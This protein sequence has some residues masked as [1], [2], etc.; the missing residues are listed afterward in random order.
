MVINMANKAFLKQSHKDVTA[1]IQLLKNT[2]TAPER[3]MDVLETYCRIGKKVGEL[4]E[5]VEVV[6]FPSFTG[7]RTGNFSDEDLERVQLYCD[8]VHRRMIQS[9]DQLIAR[10]AQTVELSYHLSNVAKPEGF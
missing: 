5:M 4:A 10:A 7:L 6:E 3:E 1:I 9:S 8:A 2:G